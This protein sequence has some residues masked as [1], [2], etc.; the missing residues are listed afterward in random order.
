MAYNTSGSFEIKCRC[1]KQLILFLL[2]W[3]T[4]ILCTLAEYEDI[5]FD[6]GGCNCFKA[7][8]TKTAMLCHV[9][10]CA[11]EWATNLHSSWNVKFY[12]H[13]IFKIQIWGVI[14]LK[15]DQTFYWTF[16]LG[17]TAIRQSVSEHNYM[18][19]FDFWKFISGTFQLFKPYN[20]LCVKVFPIATPIGIVIII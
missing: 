13:A 10:Y 20:F 11:P 15:K 17:F 5:K 8:L 3:M 14:L 16:D 1:R 18:Y 6:K 4:A 2:E 7:G 19:L 9:I 12:H